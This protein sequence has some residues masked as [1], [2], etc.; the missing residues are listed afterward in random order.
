M[1]VLTT[2]CRNMP[3]NGRP[4]SKLQKRKVQKM[5]RSV[6]RPPWLQN[7]NH[8]LLPPQLLR[9]ALRRRKTIRRRTP[10]PLRRLLMWILLLRKKK[11]LKCVHRLK[12][13]SLRSLTY[14]TQGPWLPELHDL[15]DKIKEFA[16]GNSYE[17]I[18]Y[19]IPSY[20]SL[21]LD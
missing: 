8:P 20:P 5:R 21:R 6:S 18:G 10:L 14:H 7:E 15:F 19:G 9:V 4:R 17:I 3:S 11:S 13:T 2:S 1:A 16:P 12:A